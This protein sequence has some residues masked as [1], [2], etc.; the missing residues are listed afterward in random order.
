MQIINSVNELLK[1]VEKFK[2]TGKKTGLV[3][4]MGALHAGHLSLVKQCR[5][6]NDIVMVSLFV[7]PTQFN[8][9]ADLATYPRNEE[10]DFSLLAKEGVDLVFAPKVDEIYPDGARQEKTYRLG[11]AEKVMEGEY[12]P[13]HFQ[14]VAQ[15]VDRL[16]RLCRPDRAYFGMKDFQQIIIIK[17]MVDSEGLDVEIIPCP[18]VRDE[19]GLALSSRNQLL[20]AEQRKLAPA[21]HRIL[22]ES[23]EYA[24]RHSVEDTRSQVIRALDCI[25]DFKVEYFSIV[26]GETLLPVEEWDEA[27]YIIGC[28]TVYVGK[29]R[30]IDNIV[31]SSPAKN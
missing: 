5:E 18:I 25:K 17:N 7:N 21:I 24:K 10:E 4:T 13:G 9:P 30:L 20:S 27:R 1:Q 23:R 15:I 19:D 12:R 8:N 6:D 3:P 16:F 22:S 31:Y 28:V 2:E 29:I 14:G 26:D 11:D